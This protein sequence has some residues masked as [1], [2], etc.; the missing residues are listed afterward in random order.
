MAVERFRF[1]QLSRSKAFPA[2]LVM[3]ATGGL[4]SH[5]VNTI[6]RYTVFSCQ[7]MTSDYGNFHLQS[8]FQMEFLSSQTQVLAHL[9]IRRSA[10]L[11]PDTCTNSCHSTCGSMQP[12][13]KFLVQHH[14]SCIPIT[15]L[16]W[17][18][19]CFLWCFSEIDGTK[20]EK[21]PCHMN[22]SLFMRC[23][24]NIQFTHPHVHPFHPSAPGER[25][26]LRGATSNGSAAHPKQW[27]TDRRCPGTSSGAAVNPA[28][29]TPSGA[30]SQGN[31]N[32]VTLV[33]PPKKKRKSPLPILI[34]HEKAGHT[35]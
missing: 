9:A 4:E 33:K 18:R 7:F 19:Y 26:H 15:Q 22:S 23:D 3:P 28:F 5:P 8:K 21:N 16:Q 29:G 1:V 34:E 35:A 31:D 25:L 30:D 11:T 14:F 32:E 10:A 20:L 27:A 24:A 2:G 6:H 17:W 12:T 13:Q